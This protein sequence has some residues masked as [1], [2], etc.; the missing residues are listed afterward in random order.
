MTIYHRDGK[1]L[2]ATHYCPQG[3]QPRLAMLPPSA[4]KVLRF[5]FRDATDLDTARESYVV[6]LAFDLSREGRVVRNE[7]YRRTGNDEAS[8]IRLVR[9]Q[10][11]SD[12]A[13]GSDT[14]S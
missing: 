10:P 1:G 2:I 8:E 3:N 13:S 5:K 4:A 14:S 12:R 11:S 9:E 7:T 6:A